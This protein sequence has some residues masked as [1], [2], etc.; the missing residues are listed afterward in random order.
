MTLGETYALNR[1]SSFKNLRRKGGKF[2]HRPGRPKVLLR[3]SIH[4][5]TIRSGIV[6][7]ENGKASSVGVKSVRRAAGGAWNYFS[8]VIPTRA[9]GQPRF[10]SWSGP[11]PSKTKRTFFVA[12]IFTNY[13]LTTVFIQWFPK[14]Q[15]GSTNTLLEGSG[16]SRSLAVAPFRG[17]V[18]GQR[19]QHHRSKQQLITRRG[20]ARNLIWVSINCTISNLSWVKETKQPHKKFKVD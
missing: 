18:S 16:P 8:Q 9:K 12:L 5:P 11:L 1:L 3:H 4:K 2:D 17:L 20:V 15:R 19:Y 7:S 13:P 14:F 6:D 10:E